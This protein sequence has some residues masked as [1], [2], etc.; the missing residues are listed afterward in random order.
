MNSGVSKL[1]A[2]IGWETSAGELELGVRRD[3]KLSV[4]RVCVFDT[5]V[6]KLSGWTEND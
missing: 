3:E 2:G 4:L 5:G 1:G 6:D